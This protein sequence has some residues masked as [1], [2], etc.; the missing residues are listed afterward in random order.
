MRQFKL[1]GIFNPKVRNGMSFIAS[2]FE[3]NVN[4]FEASNF[5]NV[6]SVVV[7][8]GLEDLKV[9]VE[10]RNPADNSILVRTI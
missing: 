10:R 8:M 4:L 2:N 9:T 3:L 1:Q 6:N 5:R 7:G